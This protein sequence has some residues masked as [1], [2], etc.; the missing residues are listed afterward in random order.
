MDGY[1]GTGCP[2]LTI[3]VEYVQICSDNIDSGLKSRAQLA[4]FGRATH[5]NV[6]YSFQQ[7]LV[8]NALAVVAHLLGQSTVAREVTRFRIEP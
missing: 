3:F 1:A 5:K 6:T 8:E 7:W 2:R 4:H